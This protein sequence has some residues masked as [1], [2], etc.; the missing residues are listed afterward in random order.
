MPE[1]LSFA[2]E[3]ITTERSKFRSRRIGSENW[4]YRRTERSRIELQSTR[5]LGRVW[6]RISDQV[7]AGAIR[8][9]RIRRSAL[10][11][12]NVIK[13]ETAN[14]VVKSLRNITQVATIAPDR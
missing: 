13:L 6:R 8:Y 11:R 2:L 9:D 14:D 3:H 5:T 10:P 1:K 7:G 12:N 4:R